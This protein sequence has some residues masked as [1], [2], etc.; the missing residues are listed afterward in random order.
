MKHEKAIEILNGKSF[1]DYYSMTMAVE[2]YNELTKQEIIE[3]IKPALHGCKAEFLATWCECSKSHIYMMRK[4]CYMK[5]D[6]KPSFKIFA[7]LMI[8]VKEMEMHG[9]I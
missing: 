2:A 9:E 3:M 7:S 6:T 8:I 1:N 4:K 5:M